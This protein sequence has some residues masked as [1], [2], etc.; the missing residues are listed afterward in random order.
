LLKDEEL[1]PYPVK[2]ELFG[3]FLSQDAVR[4]SLIAIYTLSAPLCSN[5]SSCHM[6]DYEVSKTLF[7][8][9]AILITGIA[10]LVSYQ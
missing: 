4:N 6:K 10:K 8:K 3:T 1:F 9:L 5:I 2:A 7:I